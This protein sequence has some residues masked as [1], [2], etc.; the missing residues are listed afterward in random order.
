[1]QEN[2]VDEAFG[3]VE[4]ETL[5]DM[6]DFMNKE[7]VRLEEERRIHAVSMLADRQR[8][9]RDAEESGRR[10]EEERR[11]REH[12][13]IF[14]QVTL[15]SAPNSQIWCRVWYKCWAG[16]PCL[17]IPSLSFA[18]FSNAIL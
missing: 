15:F 9:T 11:R 13:E 18:L 7:L 2:A 12:D 10:Q 1:M 5:S 3:S 4:G 6:L 17:Y 8:R 14:K 16:A